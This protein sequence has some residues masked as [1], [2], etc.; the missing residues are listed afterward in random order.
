MLSSSDPMVAAITNAEL[1][2]TV[3]HVAQSNLTPTLVSSFLSSGQDPRLS[4][5][6][7]RTQSVWTRTRKAT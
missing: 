2:Q 4:E 6:R 1:L 5:I 7:Y 3:R